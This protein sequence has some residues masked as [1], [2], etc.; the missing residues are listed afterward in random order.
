MSRRKNGQSW[1]EKEINNEHSRELEKEDVKHLKA[2]IIVPLLKVDNSNVLKRSLLSLV[3]PIQNMTE[4]GFIPTNRTEEGF[5]PNTYKLMLRAG[6]DFASSSTLG[7]KDPSII[8]ERKCDLTETQRKLKKYG[9]G[10]NLTKVGLGFTP[11][12][13]VKISRK[14]K[15]KKVS[16]QHISVD[17]LENEK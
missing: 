17:V 8:G 6:Y 7:K 1:F 2:V 15:D 10:V 11:I 4:C 3:R 14:M 16:T 12:S 13:P 9:Y 5:D